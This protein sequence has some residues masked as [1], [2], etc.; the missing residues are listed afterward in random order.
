MCPTCKALVQREIGVDEFSPEEKVA[1]FDAF[2]YGGLS[3]KVNWKTLDKRELMIG[4][5][6]EMREHADNFN[7][8]IG[9]KIALDH[10]AQDPQYYTKLKRAGL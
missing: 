1:L 9:M 6:E 5:G 3:H 8:L 10:L 4:L 2:W 7:E